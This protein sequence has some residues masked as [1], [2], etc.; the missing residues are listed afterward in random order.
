[1]ALI[2]D[3][4]RSEYVLK[5]AQL[6][7]E[8]NKLTYRDIVGK[9]QCA[10]PRDVMLQTREYFSN[11]Q[12]QFG[13][14]INS[15]EC[16]APSGKKFY[17][18]FFQ[19]GF[20]WEKQIQISGKVSEPEYIEHLEIEKADLKTKNTRL[21]SSIEWHERRLKEYEKANKCFAVASL[22][23]LASAVLIAAYALYLATK[24]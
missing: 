19:K 22:A 6:M 21:K 2:S 5:L 8:G 23:L 24:I 14:N 10:S 16:E 17:K 13:G 15:V 18:F 11:N 20:E 1:M 7:I 3:K 4:T 12:K 9:L